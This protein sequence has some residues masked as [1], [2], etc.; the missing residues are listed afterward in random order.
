MRK[1]YV[2]FVS[3]SNKPVGRRR[4]GGACNI[5]ESQNLPGSIAVIPWVDSVHISSNPSSIS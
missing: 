3:K 5:D 1:E 2:N 4:F